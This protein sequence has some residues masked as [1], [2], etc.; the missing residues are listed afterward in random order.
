MSPNFCTAGHCFM[1]ASKWLLTCVVKPRIIST[2]EKIVLMSSEDKIGLVF[3][4]ARSGSK[5]NFRQISQH[6]QMDIWLTSL[7]FLHTSSEV[8][9]EASVSMISLNTRNLW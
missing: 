2:D 6:I 9:Y 8:M 1:R 4:A 5:K 7:T 3:T